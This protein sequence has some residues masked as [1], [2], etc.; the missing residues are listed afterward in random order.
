M[1]RALMTGVALVSLVGLLPTAGCAPQTPCRGACAPSEA[2][3][4]DAC[5]PQTNTRDA[6]SGGTRDAGPGRTDGG[7]RDA[8]PGGTDGGP[9]DA[10]PGGG[11]SNQDVYERLLPTCGACHGQGTS[12]AYFAS[13]DTFE[14]LLVYDTDWIVPGMP[15]SSA[16]LPLLRGE[17][18]GSFSQMPLGARDFEAMAAD[19]D[20]AISMAEL[21]T[22]IQNLQPRDGGPSSGVQNAVLVRL[23]TAEQIHAAL[24][25]QLGLE[26]SDFFMPANEQYIGYIPGGRYTII[27]PAATPQPHANNGAR[28]RSALARFLALGGPD[29]LNKKARRREVSPLFLHTLVQVSQAWCARSLSKDATHLLGSVTLAQGSADAAEAIRTNIERLHLTML[30]TPAEAAQTDALFALFQSYE[31][32]PS[33]GTRTAWTA[34]CSALVRDPLWLTY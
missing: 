29:H 23:K 26:D 8:G 25:A 18:P 28:G 10:G 12:Q 27:S 20:T 30:G 11:L 14:N 13:L 31:A 15:E 34:V 33:G 4:Q 16:L 7:P 24:Y 1:R 2:C 5:V 19:G 21:T 22:W 6:G 9:R 32:R 3:V 17:A